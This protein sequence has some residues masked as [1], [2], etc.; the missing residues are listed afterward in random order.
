MVELMPG[1]PPR[2]FPPLPPLPPLD[3][4]TRVSSSQLLSSLGQDLIDTADSI[5]DIATEFGLRPYEVSL[6]MTRWSG[7]QGM[8]IKRGIGAEVI[9]ST[10][11]LLPTPLL[12]DMTGV[13]QINTPVGLDEFG[14]VLLTEV[15]ARY[16]EEQLR[17]LGPNGEPI[18][19]NVQFYYEIEF[20]PPQFAD[21]DG[22]R[23]RFTIKG[24]PMYFADKF[25]WQIRLERQ[26]GDR[27][28]NGDT[29]AL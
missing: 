12:T 2:K 13:A 27:Q 25:Q 19:K 11:P 1:I 16:R 22:Q 29:R 20:P 28:R 9:I 8:D 26:R 23:R 4:F 24:A 5:R 6:I 17:G 10:I 18:E 21:R 15:S 3:D 14:E 7:G